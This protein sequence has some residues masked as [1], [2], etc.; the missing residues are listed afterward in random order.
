MSGLR[1]LLAVLLCWALMP[2]MAS[3]QAPA[4]R[5]DDLDRMLAQAVDMQQ[6]GDLLGAVDA[7][8]IV[9]QTTPDRA[10]VRSNLG[11][12]YVKLGRFDEGMEQYRQAI[13]LDP[14]NAS[15]RFNLALALYKA[16]RP[17][18]A[19][20]E[21]RRV[22]DLDP[23]HRAALLLLADCQ[24]QTG[25]D[26]AVVATL[27]PHEAAFADDLAYA[28]LL[29]M[30]LVRTGAQERGQVFV[31]RIFK[32]G[33]SAEGHLLMGVAY[34]TAF[35]YKSAVTSFEKAV[36]LNPNL[37]R[38]YSF[39][40]RSLLSSGDAAGASR[41]LLKALE[42]NPNDFDANLQLGGIRQRDKRYD[43]ALTYLGRAAAVRP[44]DLAV[45]HAM[46][47]VFLAQGQADRALPLLEA[48]VKEAPEYV[49]AHVLLAT[50]YYRLKRKDD[51]DRE[52]Q[53]AARLTAEQ[54]SRQ[55]GARSP[56]AEA[57]STVP[58]GPTEQDR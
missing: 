11:A 17:V 21:F 58:Q 55:P 24:A 56:A 1:F 47:G 26:A 6:A 29:G 14:V 51:G 25:D 20:P 45:R 8:R 40:G 7:Y 32:A 10:D 34:M 35:D 3:A 44:N 27:S 48:V 33:E 18:D 50:T 49:D 23:N 28:Y 12:A 16:V 52:R 43:E 54:Q 41:Q 42:Q 13:R 9:L 2:G 15:Y 53:I 31:D 37:P 38:A 22:L 30:A 4:D 19:I 57:P 36:A 5:P 46:A 39:Y